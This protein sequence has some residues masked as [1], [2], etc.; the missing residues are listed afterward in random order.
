LRFGIQEKGISRA[1]RR[2]LAIWLRIA[3]LLDGAGDVGEHI[4]G[5]RSNQPNRANHD[6]QNYREHYRILGY[7]LP[8]L[9]APNG[10]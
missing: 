8:T 7:V 1:G 6:H 10:A 3:R 2:A 4:V 5:I 9:I